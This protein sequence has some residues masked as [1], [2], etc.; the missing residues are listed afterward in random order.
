MET[1][2]LHFDNT[3]AQVIALIILVVCISYLIL[4]SVIEG[5]EIKQGFK[6]KDGLWQFIE[7]AAYIW[8]IIF[9]T[10]SLADIFLGFH[11]ST[12]F[13]ASMDAIFLTI[14]GGKV[15]LEYLRKP[16]DKPSHKNNKPPD[17]LSEAV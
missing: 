8:I 10:A 1:E 2:H 17:D 5:K 11:S 4:F 3:V 7:V 15:G 12:N 6:G 13:W 14:T 16:A 9:S